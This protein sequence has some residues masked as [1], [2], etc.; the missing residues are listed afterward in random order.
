MSQESSPRIAPFN[1]TFCL[2]GCAK[3]TLHEML[4]QSISPGHTWTPVRAISWALNSIGSSSVF[5]W[6]GATFTCRSRRLTSTSWKVSLPHFTLILKVGILDT[7]WVS[8]NQ[9]DHCWVHM[10]HN[11]CRWTTFRTINT[12]EADLSAMMTRQHFIC[13]FPLLASSSHRSEIKD[14]KS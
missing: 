8:A 7:V 13:W 6:G 12:K 14:T 5:T 4:P 1:I 9:D 10:R 2:S 11:F 3:D